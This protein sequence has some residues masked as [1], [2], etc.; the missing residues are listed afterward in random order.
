M[1]V[2]VTTHALTRGIEEWSGVKEPEPDTPGMIAN[3]KDGFD[4]R[5]AHGEG[6]QWHRTREGAVR[7]AYDIQ[8]AKIKALERQIAK[9]NAMRFEIL[10]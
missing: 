3:G 9:I 2:Y 8:Q 1:K 6:K 10:D 7:R 4:R 5:Y